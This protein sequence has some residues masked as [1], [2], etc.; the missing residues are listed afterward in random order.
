MVQGLAFLS[1]KSWHTKNLN[2]QEKVWIAEE[3]AKQ[4]QLKTA[5]L[6]K[7]M[8]QEREEEELQQIAGGKERKL[9]RGIDWMYT[10][11]DKNSAVAQEDA[12]KQAEEFLLGKAIPMA[13]IQKGDIDAAANIQE[14][15]NAV[16]K[17]VSHHQSA[18]DRYNARNV[19][20]AT[21]AW[22]E[23]ES[24]AK[25]NEAFR[26]RYEDPM[27]QVSLQTV[28]HEKQR[29]QQK[30]LYHKVGME[31]VPR[32]NEG[33]VRMAED[34]DRTK[35]RRRDKR[36]E[37]KREKGDHSID[38]DR[39][40]RV[41]RSRKRSRRD[42]SE[43]DS[44]DSCSIASSVSDRRRHHARRTTNEH[45]SKRR[46]DSSSDEVDIKRHR[47]FS[48]SRAKERE[49]KHRYDS[50][51]SL[52]DDRRRRYDSFSEED[53]T[54]SFVRKRRHSKRRPM[55]TAVIRSMDRDLYDS[56]A[57]RRSMDHP[58]NSR[59]HVD[60]DD[61]RSDGSYDRRRDDRRGE[62]GNK[63]G[64]HS[65]RGTHPS[66]GLQRSTT[67]AFSETRN[68]SHA[69]LGPDPELRRHKRHE[70]QLERQTIRE[71]ASQRRYQSAEDRARAL[72]TMADQA[73]SREATRWHLDR[74]AAD[75]PS[76]R[77][78]GA[79]FV[80]EFSQQVHGVRGPQND[81][82]HRDSM[83]ARLQQ[84]RNSHQRRHDDSFL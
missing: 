69:V 66:Y 35:Q 68:V 76:P 82:H 28:R 31:V 40:R 34:D 49:A 83:S 81:A 84:N 14:G 37:R 39:K 18:D 79:R 33:D 57:R 50:P 73:I 78:G 7:Q 70:K 41:H 71:H 58:G 55:N 5:E 54:D 21:S 75:D 9:D 47:N 24:V 52:G 64:L 13:S 61:N 60:E 72:R 59:Y 46:Y 45:R 27:Y 15:V 4:E 36:K 19:P 10:G 42:S 67:S 56:S 29:E 53:S 17:T 25:R 38:S 77:Q 3:Q 20:P 62:M 16:V 43:H 80:Q 2:N 63:K 12:V 30:E 22:D 1:K 23:E 8:Q 32:P 11:H 6:Q 74:R 65:D 26:L 48:S 51:L 44:D